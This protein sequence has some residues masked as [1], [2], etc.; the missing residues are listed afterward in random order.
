MNLAHLGD[1][2][3]HWKGSLIKVI[4]GRN[5]RIVPMITDRERWVQE[6]FETY[7]R[8]LH[9]KSEDVLKKGKDDV[10]SSRTRSGYFCDLGE[11]DLFLDPDTG[12]APDEK[13]HKKHIRPS[14]IAD[15]LAESESRMLLIYQHASREQDGPK[16]K[17]ELLR[18]TQGLRECGIFAYD[19]RCCQHGCD[20]PEAGTN[21]Q[22]VSGPQIL[23][24]PCRLDADY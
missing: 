10:F 24:R 3:D 20:I 15:L 23:A 14:E 4:G 9:R 18:S 16:K 19:F 8:L 22:T 2:L 21:R 17:V 1:A 12:I 5:L 6:H 13:A 7:A 11:D